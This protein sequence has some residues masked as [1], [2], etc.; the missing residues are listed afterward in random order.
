MN[1]TTCIINTF[2]QSDT[3]SLNFYCPNDIESDN[4]EHTAKDCNSADVINVNLF[5]V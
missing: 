3:P 1:F 4:N 2:S 5:L